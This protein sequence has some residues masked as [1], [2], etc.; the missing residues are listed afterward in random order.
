MVSCRFRTAFDPTHPPT[1]YAVQPQ[2]STPSAACLL[3]QQRRGDNVAGP[4][5]IADTT[6]AAEAYRLVA[7]HLSGAKATYVLT[8]TATW[9]GVTN[10]KAIAVRDG[11]AYYVY[12]VNKSGLSSAILAQLKLASLGIGAGVPVF[13]DRVNAV[14]YGE[15]SEQLTTDA[16]GSVSVVSAP[17]DD[18]SVLL[19][20]SRQP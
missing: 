20:S 4:F 2:C 5:N 10:T 14:S 8:S 7:E 3:P 15:V 17:A 18:W 6:L 12:I 11:N 16:T 13:V 9:T 19:C 1:H